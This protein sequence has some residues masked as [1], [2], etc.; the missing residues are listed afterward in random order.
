M[1][2]KYEKDLESEGCAGPEGRISVAIKLRLRREVDQLTF[3]PPTA[4]G[5][6][7]DHI[8]GLRAKHLLKR[9]VHCV[10]SSS[11]MQSEARHLDVISAST[12]TAG[13]IDQKYQ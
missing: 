10:Q 11:H 5:A 7:I 13:S 12:D 3:Q 6:L 8:M 2:D 1:Y 4:E 9:E